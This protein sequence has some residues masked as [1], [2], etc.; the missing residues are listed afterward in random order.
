MAVG[1]SSGSVGSCIISTTLQS[2]VCYCE[3]Q[4]ASDGY[5]QCLGISLSFNYF[6]FFSCFLSSAVMAFKGMA[7]VTALKV[8]KAQPAT[9]V[10]AQTSTARTVMKVSNSD[11]E[12]K[13]KFRTRI[14]GQIPLLGR[15]VS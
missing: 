11:G 14:M 4:S 9:S 8:S 12:T 7:T 15:P 6:G 1:H 3:Y 10:P 5:H 13:G 2:L